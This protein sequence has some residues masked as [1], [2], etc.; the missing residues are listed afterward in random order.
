[1][2]QNSITIFLTLDD[3]LNLEISMY[4][5]DD[6]NLT[7]QPSTLINDF[8]QPQDSP[9]FKYNNQTYLTSTLNNEPVDKLQI[10]DQDLENLYE[11]LSVEINPISYSGDNI[12]YKP[13]AYQSSDEAFSNLQ[14][15]FM[16]AELKQDELYEQVDN[17]EI[18]QY[19]V[20]WHIMDEPVIIEDYFRNL[21]KETP[22]QTT[23]SYISF[24]G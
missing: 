21:F 4:N 12:Q 5:K 10:T 23:S 7:P 19:L 3:D 1:M 24:Y 11:P 6:T 18:G 17:M 2:I 8:L 20:N 15:E 16:E 14:V 9:I 13:T 22:I